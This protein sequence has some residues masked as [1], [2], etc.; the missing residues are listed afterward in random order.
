[1]TRTL[2]LAALFLT[3]PAAL[4]DRAAPGAG[5]PPGISRG[6]GDV[7]IAVAPPHP[8]KAA[9]VELLEDDA[10]WLAPQ[11]NRAV[12]PAD[13]DQS[14]RAGPWG[15]DCY[16]GGACLKVAGYQR[17]DEHIPG[18]EYP[19]VE[20]PRPG[21]YRY[22]RFAWKKPAGAGVMV[23]LCVSGV[24]WH[25]YYAGTNLVGFTPAIQVSTTLPEE[26]QVVTRDLYADYGAPHT[27]TGFAFTSMDGVALYDHVYLGRTI[28]DLDKV[29]AAAKIGLRPE[30]FTD[31]ELSA[32]FKNL[33]SEDAAVR[34]P[35][36]WA[37]GRD[38]AGS[39]KYLNANYKLPDPS[40]ALTQ[41]RKAIAD[42]D[43]PR[44]AVREAAMKKL[45]LFGATATAPLHEA[46]RK[47]DASPE[48]VERA[49]KLIEKH[50]LNGAPLT[51][52]AVRLPLAVLHVLEQA[53]TAEAT[54]LLE[55]VGKSQASPT[56]G[57]ET[58]AAME[59]LAKRI[60]K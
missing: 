60:R 24:D 39:V 30:T 8:A 16:S 21:E 31:A 13:R 43:S 41:I 53:E 40:D 49:G 14:G 11:L 48:L 33:T 32:H 20:K 23:Q 38:A 2:M 56:V 50:A 12:V 25:R 26:W 17:Y 19:V 36:L 5:S 1:M 4:A 37:M 42:L 6:P 57:F 28:A 58:T 55:R 29:T 51:D 9:V 18:W 7:G 35:A 15:E 52:P 47:P 22:V 27:L 54:A 3:A 34:N 10:A 45:D 59:R 44:Y 46:R